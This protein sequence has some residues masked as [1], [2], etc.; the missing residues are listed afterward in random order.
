M[1]DPKNDNSSHFNI[2]KIDFGKC[3]SSRLSLFSQINANST[4]N[5]YRFNCIQCGR[6]FT[7]K[8]SLKTHIKMVHQTIKDNKCDKCSYT[9]ST[10][11]NLK[12]HIKLKHS[13][14][15]D[16]KCKECSYVTALKSSLNPL[17]G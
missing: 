4:I 15:R 17:L 7:Q 16:F 12:V 13:L 1:E 2:E 3:N 5:C 10:K 14:T 8:Q 6:Q 9:S 11:G